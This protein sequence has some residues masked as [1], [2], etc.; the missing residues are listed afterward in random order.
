VRGC[1]ALLRR[2]S[3]RQSSAKAPKR[4]QKSDHH[5]SVA[6]A[7]ASSVTASIG[8]SAHRRRALAKERTLIVTGYE[9]F[10]VARVQHEVGEGAPD[11]RGTSR[12]VTPAEMQENPYD[13]NVLLQTGIEAD[14][15][16][17]ATAC[18]SPLSEDFLLIFPAATF[19]LLL[20]LTVVLL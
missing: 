4:E 10:A 18:S 20:A 8:A 2:S 3:Q 13:P 15:F 9:N 7:A 6:D 16:H 5:P 11:E 17:R 19:L 14:A 1:L 12:H